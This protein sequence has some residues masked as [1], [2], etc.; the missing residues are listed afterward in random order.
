M[1]VAG[2]APGNRDRTA[3]EPIN[4]SDLF[5]MNSDGTEQT[6]LTSGSSASWSPDGKNIT[7]HASAS[8]NGTPIRTDPGSATSDSDIFVANVDDL[9]AGL[10]PNP[11]RRAACG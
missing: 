4:T 10:R 2:T 5:L 1:F 9:L 11:T 3:D 8:G 7:F 6:R